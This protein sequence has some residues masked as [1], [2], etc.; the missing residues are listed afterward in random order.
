[1]HS[2]P[3]PERTVGWHSPPGIGPW[4]LEADLRP[5]ATWGLIHPSA[6][7]VNSA[8]FACTEFSKCR[9]IKIR[10]GT[11]A[12]TLQRLEPLGAC[13][14]VEVSYLILF[15]C[16]LLGEQAVELMPKL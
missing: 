5:D 14:H 3:S 4:S 12:P 6:W 10:T 9:D 1:M 15:P 11:I 16:G 7:K 2:A 8:N 13:G